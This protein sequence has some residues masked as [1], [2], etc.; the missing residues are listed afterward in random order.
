MIARMR[1]LERVGL[2]EPLGS[3]RWHLSEDAEPTMRALGERTDIIKRIHRGLATHRIER[4]ASDFVLAEEGARQP[5]IGRLVAR[6]LDDELR[7]T[8]YAVIDAAD[9]RAH[10]VRL[11]DL[12]AA[13]DVAPG[14]IVELRRFED[15]AG[16]QRVALAVRSD[17]PLE[18]QIQ[19]S[20][21]T[22]LDRQ[23]LGRH[24]AALTLSGFGLEVRNALDARAEH[25][26]G[27]GL[28]RR[29][30]Q[31]VIFARDLLETLRRR[32]L[33][34]IAARVGSSAGLPYHRAVEGETVGG[35]YRQRLD[36][37]SGRFAMI[38]D[39]LGF[40]LVPWSPSLERHLG[41]QVSGIAQPG[42]IEWSF[43]RARGP[44]I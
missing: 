9:G 38:D 22:W 37:A 15:A 5:I 18:A 42:R 23:L 14:G 24:P 30:G 29:Q 25:L 12:D 39:G 41:R 19:A 2:A 28:A 8:A 34:A 40:S 26:I 44:T 31:R 21:A 7:G 3:T 36:L 33:E 35:V 17:L 1:K 43:G 11:A 27:Q 16:R 32:E 20:G 4:S 10:H 13:S 6:G